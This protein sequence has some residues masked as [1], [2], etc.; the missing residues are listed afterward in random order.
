MDFL[1]DLKEVLAVIRVRLGFWMVRPRAMATQCRDA[2]ARAR[3][4]TATLET[5]T[6]AV[7]LVFARR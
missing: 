5:A 7:L 2:V 1:K 3:S 6:G 4:K